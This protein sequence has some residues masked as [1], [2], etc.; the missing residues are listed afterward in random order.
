MLIDSGLNHPI[1]IPTLPPGP[2]RDKCEMAAHAHLEVSS[3]QRQIGVVSAELAALRGRIAAARRSSCTAREF[4]EL[5]AEE[6]L[7]AR[8]LSDAEI[9]L[10]ERRRRLNLAEG[11]R[12]RAIKEYRDT[13]E[14][15]ET[16]RQQFA[17]S[18][19]LDQLRTKLDRMVTG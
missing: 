6:V 17:P 8:D 11:E 12:D 5:L 15:L 2:L 19:L 10:A 3:T 1:S 4:A 14:R 7:A 18:E 9:V 13:C 16:A